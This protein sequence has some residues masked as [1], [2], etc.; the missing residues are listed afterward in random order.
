ML[1]EKET[2]IPTHHEKIKIAQVME[3][4][5]KK[6]TNGIEDLSILTEQDD[7][8]MLVTKMKDLVPEFV[9]NNSLYEEIDS[10]RKQEQEIQTAQ[11][12]EALS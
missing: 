12:F 11:K 7:S 2:T 10:M 6:I 4:S 8:Y 5:F 9:S 3:C 1:N